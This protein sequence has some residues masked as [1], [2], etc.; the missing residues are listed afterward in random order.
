[1]FV[2]VSKA[3]PL[4]PIESAAVVATSVN[5]RFFFLL[6]VGQTAVSKAPVET[7]AVF[8]TDAGNGKSQSGGQECLVARGGAMERK[9]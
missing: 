1:M 5:S 2:C 9:C 3:V 7:A 4:Q 8:T 6:E